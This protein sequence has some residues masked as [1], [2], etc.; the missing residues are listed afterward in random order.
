MPA[1]RVINEGRPVDPG[2]KRSAASDESAPQ[3]SARLVVSKPEADDARAQD[4]QERKRLAVGLSPRRPTAKAVTQRP[5]SVQSF[6]IPPVVLA[7]ILVGVVAITALLVWLNVADTR[8]AWWPA[9]R[10]APTVQPVMMGDAS[11]VAYVLRV[12]DDFSAPQSALRQGALSGE[13]RTELV[14]EQSIYRMTIWPNRLAWSLLGVD[15]L[16]RYRLQA[17]VAIAATAP[18]GYAGLMVRHQIDQGFY[19]FAVD[20]SGRYSVQ[21]QTHD[22]TTVLQP[23]TPTPA[24]QPAPSVNLLTVEDRG[25][26]IHFYANQSLLYTLVEPALPMGLVGLAAGA[27]G[28]EVA[29]VRFDWFQLYEAVMPAP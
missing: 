12:G 25:D 3:T 29:E 18:S 4:E 5:P 26:L 13:W 28:P 9:W 7:L 15:A 24:L 17:G 23:W 21:V 16:A 6:P 1:S 20:G 22:G 10:S 27:H 11:A 2:R 14:P 8:P 19:F